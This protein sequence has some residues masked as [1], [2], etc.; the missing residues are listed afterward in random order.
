MAKTTHHT[1]EPVAPQP[2]PQVEP[3]A[4]PQ[5]PQQQ[6]YYQPVYAAPLPPAPKQAKYPG[7][8]LALAV[9]STFA[10]VWLLT[11]AL[12]G[13]IV[14]F[15]NTTPTFGVLTALF[16]SHLS[17]FAGIIITAFVS[18]AFATLAFWLFRRLSSAIESDDYKLTL[19]IGVGVAALKTI[20]LAATTLAVGLTPLLTIQKGLSVGPT[21]L[22]NF[23]P[24]FIATVLFGL[25]T[26]YFL[27]LAGKKQ[28]GRVLSTIVLVTSSVV[29]LLGVVAVIVKSHSDSYRPAANYIS[30]PTVISDYTRGSENSSNNTKSQNKTGNDNSSNSQTENSNKTA[31]DCYDDYKKDNDSTKYSACI[32]KV[33]DSY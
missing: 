23:L 7:L 28:V 31:S 18:I 27:Q 22:H 4:A 10:A 30:T 21:Y 25:V 26:W 33:F 32:N 16:V 19:H 24:L 12:T 9:V 5:P 15:A 1:E 8:E 13:S 11:E 29:L 3:I 20:V 6:Q 2:Q 17:G 14:L